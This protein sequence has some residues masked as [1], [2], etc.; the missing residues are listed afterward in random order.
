MSH[1]IPIHCHTQLSTAIGSVQ[2]NRVKTQIKIS[3]Y[4]DGRT[5]DSIL[6]NGPFNKALEKVEIVKQNL[7]FKEVPAT[8][9]RFKGFLA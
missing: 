3:E 5:T 7:S 9:V 8:L 2:Q 4:Y 6:D 1:I